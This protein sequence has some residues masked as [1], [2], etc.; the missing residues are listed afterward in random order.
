MEGLIARVEKKFKSPGPHPNGLQAADDGL[1]YIDQ[2]DNKIYKLTTRPA[3][4]SSRRR[5]I[6]S[7]RAALH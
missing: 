1:W 6:R 2:V 3:R 7:T 4:R 5:P